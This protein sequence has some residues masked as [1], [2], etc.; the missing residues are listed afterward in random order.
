MFKQPTRLGGRQP[1]A[2]RRPRQR[3]RSLAPLPRGTPP[4]PLRAFASACVGPLWLPLIRLR[5]KSVSAPLPWN[6]KHKPS[7][8]PLHRHNGDGESK[9]PGYCRPMTGGRC[10]CG[11]DPGAWSRAR[12]RGRLT[13]P[14]RCGTKG[15]RSQPCCCLVRLQNCRSGAPH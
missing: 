2:R 14:P 8:C 10:Q 15:H 11:R 12:G 4:P 6:D 3:G 1:Q 5:L 13:E 9:P 7:C